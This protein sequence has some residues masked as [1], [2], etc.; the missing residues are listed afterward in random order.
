M[1]RSNRTTSTAGY[2]SSFREAS[3]R[4]TS[5]EN[6]YGRARILPRTAQFAP[7]GQRHAD[8]LHQLRGAASRRGGILR[9]ED[10]IVAARAVTGSPTPTPAAEARQ[11]ATSQRQ[12]LSPSRPLPG[13]HGLAR[14]NLEQNR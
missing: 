8:R 6:A 4:Q 11:P 3:E 9:E 2:D 7:S 10:P 1:T 13:S 5:S 12:S 14:F